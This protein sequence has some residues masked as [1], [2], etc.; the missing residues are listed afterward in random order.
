MTN[1]VNNAQTKPIV[2]AE[3]KF[4]LKRII[5]ELIKCLLHSTHVLILRHVKGIHKIWSLQGHASRDMKG[6]FAQSVKKGIIKEARIFVLNV[7][8]LMCIMY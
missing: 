3:T 2:L 8:S 5:G 1:T 4:I 6:P 7:W